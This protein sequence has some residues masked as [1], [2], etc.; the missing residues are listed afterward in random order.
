MVV[1]YKKG[2]V[3]HCTMATLFLVLWLSYPFTAKKKKKKIK[4]KGQYSSVGRI[5]ALF[6][7]DELSYNIELKI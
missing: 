5:Q 3:V 6:Q 7:W 4:Y 1:V 2:Y